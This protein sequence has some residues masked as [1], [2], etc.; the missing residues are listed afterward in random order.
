[1]PL[2]HERRRPYHRTHVSARLREASTGREW[3][4]DDGDSWFLGRASE[5]AVLLHE[6]SIARRHARIEWRLGGWWIEDMGSTNGTRLNGMTVR[7]DELRN[8]DVLACGDVSFVFHDDGIPPRPAPMRPDDRARLPQTFVAL[9]TI[10]SAPQTWVDGA[11]I[12]ARAGEALLRFCDRAEHRDELKEAYGRAIGSPWP[13]VRAISAHGL[14]ALTAAGAM[15]GINAGAAIGVLLDDPADFVQDS[16]AR[17]LAQVDPLA[18]APRLHARALAALE[19]G[20]EPRSAREAVAQLAD[21]GARPF[22]ASLRARAESIA[23]DDRVSARRSCAAGVLGELA[24]AGDTAALRPLRALLADATEEVR[25]NAIRAL[26]RAVGALDDARHA[27]RTALAD[28]SPRV[29]H[30]AC[31][32]LSIGGDTGIAPALVT[33]LRAVSRHDVER[34]ARYRRALEDVTGERRGPDPDAWLREA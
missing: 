25:I 11:L 23:F 26:A 16:A 9:M 31:R 12:A 20:V 24:A 29:F 30:E 34:R 1:M 13:V 17:A 6:G 19:H 2:H 4:L 15:D 27:L 3:R 18:A 21:I 22:L 7:R 8:G 10:F 32:A 33:A 5:C 14:A 28:P